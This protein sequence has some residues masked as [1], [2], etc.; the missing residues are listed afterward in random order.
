MRVIQSFERRLAGRRR[1]HLRTPVRRQGAARRGR[2]R[3]A[4]GSRGARP[5]AG[6]RLDRP[7]SLP[8]AARAD[9]SAGSWLRRR[10]CRLCVVG[11]DPG[12]SGRAGMANLRG[13]RGQPRAVR[14]PAH[15]AVP[16]QLDRRSRRRS[17]FTAAKGRSG[18]H[19]PAARRFRPPRC[20]QPEQPRPTRGPG[21]TR[22]PAV[23]AARLPA[24]QV[25]TAHPIRAGLPGRRTP[26]TRRSPMTHPATA[27]GSGTSRVSSGNSSTASSSRPR[28]SPASS[29]RRRAI[30]SSPTSRDSRSHGPAGDQQGYPQQGQ[31]AGSTSRTTART[32]A[33]RRLHRRRSPP[34]CRSM[35]VP[36]AATS[37]SAG[38][39]SSAVGRTPRS[40]SPTRRSPGGMSMSTSTASRRCCTTSGRPTAPPSTAR[41]SRPGNSRTAT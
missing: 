11:H 33:C 17:T 15:R 35:T 12:V 28:S 24:V 39:T 3:P 38:R 8:G 32:T 22:G 1:Q 4:E 2:R 31:Q 37:C 30:P 26:G 9:R 5:A 18:T 34:R 19:D 16:H 40:G 29:T 41:P 7:E 25:P 27:S 20:P 23:R 13:C 10:E 6:Q 36:A 21:P 14:V